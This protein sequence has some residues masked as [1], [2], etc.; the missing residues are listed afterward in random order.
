MPV[1]W[2]PRRAVERSRRRINAAIARLRPVA[3]EW[4]DADQGIVREVEDA[5]LQL[6]ELRDGIKEG[7][8]ER[9]R[10]GESVGY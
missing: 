7:I 4:D 1:S 8:E 2:T 10:L 5:I 3:L 9:L 6:E